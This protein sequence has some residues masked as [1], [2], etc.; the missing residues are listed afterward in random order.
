M[1]N[2]IG[3]IFMVV[4]I[5]T[6]TALFFLSGVIII[7]LATNSIIHAKNRSSDVF[8]PLFISTMTII[9]ACSI[10]AILRYLTSTYPEGI[11][12]KAL[13]YVIFFAISFVL[14]FSTHIGNV[15]SRSLPRLKPDFSVKRL[16]LVTVLFLSTG[17]ALYLFIIWKAGFRNPLELLENLRLFR[18]FWGRYGW[19]YVYMFSIFLIEAPFWG[20]ILWILQRDSPIKFNLFNLMLSLYFVF[21]IVVGLLSGTRSS[22]IL[23][24]FSLFFIYHCK[25]KRIHT[26]KVLFAAVVSIIP[27]SAFYV[28]QGSYR[29]INVKIGRVVQITQQL[30]IANALLL[31]IGRFVACFDGFVSILLNSNRL[32]LLWGASFY[33]VLFMPIPRSLIPDK[34]YSFSMQMTKRLFHGI[35][36]F[37]AEFSILGELY[38]NF[39]VA[40]L[41][42]GGIVFGIIIKMMQMYYISNQK[43]ISF[44]F[45]YRTLV[46]LPLAWFTNGLIN[47]E[48]NALLLLNLFFGFIFFRL[49]L[50][51]ST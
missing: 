6:S 37:G 14:G 33:D 9:V 13:L 16:K 24:V 20:W 41:L 34:P 44:L 18:R 29:G 7:L 4:S 19:A 51:S 50:Q 46:F 5:V 15:L 25:K 36:F 8:S 28:I 1:L 39:H 30:D 2:I 32:N 38:M 42:I 49:V 21:I 10:G 31:F 48:A 45:L 35:E 40:G 3:I 23:V 47:S 12:N 43:N 17:V 22:V 26:F 27:L 11:L